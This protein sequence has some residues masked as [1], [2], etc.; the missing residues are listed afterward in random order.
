MVDI[1]MEVYKLQRLPQLVFYPTEEVYKCNCHWMTQI[2]ALD[3][4]LTKGVVN[5]PVHI[6]ACLW[7]GLFIF[8]RRM[9]LENPWQSNQPAHQVI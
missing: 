5:N 1:K 8:P 4:K 9:P 2:M 6:L 3:T 7:P